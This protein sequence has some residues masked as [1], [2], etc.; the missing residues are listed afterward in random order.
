MAGNGTRNLQATPERRPQR[1]TRVLLGGLV[2]FFD[3]AQHFD[4]TIRDLTKTGARISLPRNQPIPSNV[5]LINMRDR[6]AHQA[7]VAW[8]NGKGAGL[9]FVKSLSL[10]EITDPKLAYLKRLWHERAAR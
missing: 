6:T 1:R 10:S 9:S 4:C 3:G 2:A 8:N 7:K 5:Y